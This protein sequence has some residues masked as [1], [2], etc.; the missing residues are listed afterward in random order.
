VTTDNTVHGVVGGDVTQF[1]DVVNNFTVV[2]GA[3]RRL[4]DRTRLAPVKGFV[5][6][7]GFGEALRR[8][9]TGRVLALA[10][11][12]GTGRR[13]AATCLLD[14]LGGLHLVE[15]DVDDEA[16]LARHPVSPKEGYLLDLTDADDAATA[17]VANALHDFATR[18]TEEDSNLVI[19]VP[20][21]HARLFPADLL[22]ELPPP[23]ASEV[24]RAH[25]AEPDGWLADAEINRLLTTA[26]VADAARL[27][28][29]IRRVGNRDDVLAAYTNWSTHLTAQFKTH[30]DVPARALLLSVAVLEHAHQDTILTASED[31]LAITRYDGDRPHPLAGEG[32]AAR[33]A[34]IDAATHGGTVT[35]AKP[36]Y[37]AAV[38][39]H[40]WTDFP[41]LREPLLRWLTAIPTSQRLSSDDGDRLAAHLID[42]ARRRNQTGPVLATVT[43]WSQQSSTRPLAQRL[44]AAAA[45]D[46]VIG[47]PTRRAIYDWSRRGDLPV[48]LASVAIA[49]CGGELG[50]RYPYMALTRLG[51]FVRRQELADDVITALSTL[52]GGGQF[53]HVVNRLVLWLRE[54]ARR[55]S[56][57]KALLDEA[58]AQPQHRDTL[59][60]RLVS[61]AAGRPAE[62]GAIE[63]AAF[64]WRRAGGQRQVHD[65]LLAKLNG[66]DPLLRSAISR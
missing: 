56:A 24:L 22:A 33:L 40:V 57:I 7:E 59:L 4:L 3:Y 58:A 29:L 5:A 6:P 39:D 61:T 20:N 45:L 13:T 17:L 16:T 19:V 51:H 9:A 21:G 15:I 36:D 46:P 26:S 65:L 10:G 50:S 62:L 25:L 23:P 38:I 32:L 52:A 2:T 8:L 63:L 47:H 54:P 66:V 34:A 53:A 31:L 42:L 1:R 49:V 12:R 14:R 60:D 28:A 55:E 64:Q 37:A 48:P 44:L 30:P 27:A 41:P 35:F 11:K 18:L 43:T